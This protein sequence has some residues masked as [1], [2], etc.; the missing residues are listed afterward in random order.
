MTFSP[1]LLYVVITVFSSAVVS[2]HTDRF[3]YPY[4]VECEKAAKQIKKD[5]HW[6][7]KLRNGKVFSGKKVRSKVR[8]S[9]LSIP[10]KLI[11]DPRNAEQP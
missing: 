10:G 3:F 8:T 9:C 1:T 11:G 6:T 5:H 4:M 7:L 2:V